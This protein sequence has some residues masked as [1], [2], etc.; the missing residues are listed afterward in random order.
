MKHLRHD[1]VVI[2]M[3]E[4]EYRISQAIDLLT[5]VIEDQSEHQ[6]IRSGC[7]SAR[8]LAINAVLNCRAEEP[9]LIERSPS[10][11]SLTAVVETASRR[12]T[13]LTWRPWRRKPKEPEPCPQCFGLGWCFREEYEGTSLEY[14]GPVCPR[15]GTAES[16]E[17]QYA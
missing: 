6:A 3:T 15:C 4:N 12:T 8:E 16:T 10:G 2:G 13:L 5:L 17:R 14:C 7:R 11:D 1:Q 9:V